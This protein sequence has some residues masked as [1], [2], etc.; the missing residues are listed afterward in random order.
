MGT[1]WMCYSTPNNH[2]GV[3][4]LHASSKS[5]AMQKLYTSGLLPPPSA[6]DNAEELHVMG[7]EL[8]TKE[9][10]DE[11]K[12]LKKMKSY[13]LE[14]LIQITGKSYTPISFQEFLLRSDRVN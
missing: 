10:L 9:E 8:V 7:I 6:L 5:D 14:Q 12:D 3:V 2:M 1:Y 4:I 11:V 13:N